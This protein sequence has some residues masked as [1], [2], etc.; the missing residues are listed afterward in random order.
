MGQVRREM[1]VSFRELES[2]L[3]GKLQELFIQTMQE[4]LEQLD[5]MLLVTRDPA[6]YEVKDTRERTVDT[7]VGTVTYRRRYYRDRE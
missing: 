2:F 1:V 4:I 3:F 6:R 7:L 5:A